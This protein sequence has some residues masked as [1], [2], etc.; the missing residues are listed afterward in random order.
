MAVS[1][2][3]T[4]GSYDERLPDSPAPV[5]IQ[6]STCVKLKLGCRI[7]TSETARAVEKKGGG[8]LSGYYVLLAV[9]AE[10]FQVQSLPTTPAT[11][12]RASHL[13]P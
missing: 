10:T 13:M 12:S 4:R 11:I 2:S 5:C 1:L 7:W 9:A 8:E 3:R 6:P